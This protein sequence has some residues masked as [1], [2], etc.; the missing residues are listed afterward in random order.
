LTQERVD[1]EK[2]ISFL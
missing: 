2:G 1:Q